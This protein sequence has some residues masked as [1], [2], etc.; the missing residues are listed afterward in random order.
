LRLL[1]L[2]QELH[3]RVIG[4]DEAVRA[5]ARAIRR[6]RTLIRDMRRPIGTFLFVGSVGVGKTELARALAVSLF[7]DERTLFQYD[8]S[9]FMEYHQV[10]RLIGSPPGY[11]G[12]EQGGQLTEVVRRHPYCVILFDEIEKAHPKILD[13]LLQV[14]EDGNLTDARGQLVSFNHTI[15]IITSNIGAEYDIAKAPLFYHNID[16]DHKHSYE[17][18]HQHVLTALKQTFRSELLN[19]IDEII[20]FHSLNLEHLHKIVR[21]LIAQTC[22]LLAKQSIELVVTEAACLL[23]VEQGYTPEYGARPLRRT[24]Q[25]LLEDMLADAILEGRLTAGDTVEAG[26]ANGHLYLRTS[27]SQ[28]Q[29]IA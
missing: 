20:V 7:G 15:I 16:N 19:R 11:I 6:A 18:M 1:N 22:K 4:Q 23:L 28:N 10:S 14:F 3:Q 12:Y 26:A 25:C 21:L 5:V 9:E 29:A 24:V 2:E 17:K 13:L 8:M 27:H